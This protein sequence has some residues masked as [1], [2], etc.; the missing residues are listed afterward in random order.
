M[1]EFCS[2]SPQ[3]SAWPAQIATGKILQSRRIIA[4]EPECGAMSEAEITRNQRNDKPRGAPTVSRVLDDVALL[5]LVYDPQKQRTGLAVWDGR[6]WSIKDSV[7]LPSGECLVPY[8]ASNNLIKNDVVL[9][10]Q[11]PAESGSDGELIRDIQAFIH[12]YVDVSPRFEQI[13]ASYVLFSWIYDRFNALP[14]LRLRGDYGSGKTRFLL[15]V[16][17]LCYRPMFASAASSMSAV[18]R[19]VDAFRGTLIVDEADFRFSD[20]TSEIIKLLNH[21]NNARMPILRTEVVGN[22][23]F[24]PRAFHVYGPKIIATRGYFQDRALETRCLTEEVGQRRLRPDI[25][26]NLPETYA[27]EA[28]ALRNRLLLYRFHN[29]AR[30]HAN[31][32][33]VDPQ[34]EPRLNQVFVPL[35]S[36]VEREELRREFRALARAYQREL[37]D[38]RG[39]EVE[40]QVLEII[41]DLFADAPVVSIKAVTARFV[42][43]FG[44]EYEGQITNKWIGTIIRR[45]LHLRPHKSHGTF[46]LS[47]TEKPKLERL[48]QKYGL[49]MLAPENLSPP[50]AGRPVADMAETAGNA[51]NED[52]GVS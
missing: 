1:K 37:T 39:M 52:I 31:E 33:L 6:N 25:P 36:I 26:I 18:F 51:G 9:L 7:T 27:D 50:D 28:R 45:K 12:R 49:A 10:P 21:G 46:V 43:R 44:K 17:S 42:E 35:L 3:Q 23:E 2:G 32:A 47:L 38:E 22:R 24:N 41:R 16:G 8:S 48:C 4:P 34:I 20:E 14:Y 19:T 13:A 30:A 5:E 11:E 40:A 29:R 15:T